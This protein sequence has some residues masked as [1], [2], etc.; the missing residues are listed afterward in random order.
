MEEKILKATH[1]GVLT[2]GDSILH[3]AVLEDGTSVLTQGD[4]LTAI[5]RVKKGKRV[6]T[7]LPPFLSANNLKPFIDEELRWSSTPIVFKAKKGGGKSGIA[8][9][10]KAELLTKV[11]NVFLRARDA[12]VLNTSQLHIAINCK[13]LVRALA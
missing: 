10:Y 5:G 3:C 6:V 9:G 8:H 11:C 7:K 2:I 13:I 1:E 4:F 12:G